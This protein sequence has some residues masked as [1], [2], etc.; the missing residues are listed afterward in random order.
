M[1]P[2]FR[3][4]GAMADTA[5]SHQ[6][7]QVNI[8]RLLAPLDHPQL[9]E[10]VTNLDPVNA[11]AEQA[12]G[13]VWRLKDEAGN[14]TQIEAFS[15]DVG[16]SA[17]LI[18]NMSVWVDMEHLTD[19]V[20]GAMHRAVLRQRRDWFASVQE[21]TT[22][23]WWVPAGE[24]PTTGDA[25]DRVRHLRA[26]GPTPWAFTLRE[27]FPAPAPGGGYEPVSTVPAAR[28]SEGLAQLC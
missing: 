18:V 27:H 8:A 5:A 28:T 1:A 24:T 26:H 13:F 7:A 14:A 16:E 12:D 17:G 10:F 15:W 11:E 3:H 23:C 21:H 4:N 20:Y 2:A 22:G 9:A 19:F 6:L 25:E